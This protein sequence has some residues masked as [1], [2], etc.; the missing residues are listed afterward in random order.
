MVREMEA[1]TNRMIGK[2]D[3]GDTS[4]DPAAALGRTL[5]LHNKMRVENAIIRYHKLLLV[6]AS[7]IVGSNR[8]L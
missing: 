5:L 7:R 1:A 3:L 4:I 2:L 8:L 6:G